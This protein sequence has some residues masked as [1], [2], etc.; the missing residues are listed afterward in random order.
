MRNISLFLFLIGI[1]L[2]V[3][4]IIPFVFAFP[5][6]DIPYS[7]PSN[8]WELVVMISY[9][10]KGWSLLIGIVISLFSLF[11]RKQISIINNK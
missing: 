3:F 8:F 11:L 6:S 10:S 5:Y 1:V 2:T 7:G 9:D 4:G